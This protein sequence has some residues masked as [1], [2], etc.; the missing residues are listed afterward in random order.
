MPKTSSLSQEK[1][2]TREDF[3]QI[4]EG[5]ARLGDTAKALRASGL[6]RKAVVVLLKHSTGMS[7]K[8]ITNVLDNLEDLKRWC[9]HG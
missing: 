9:L 2:P 6:S 5:I 8:D 7:A 4:A 1:K 3:K